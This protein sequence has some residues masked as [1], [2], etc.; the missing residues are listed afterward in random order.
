M[1]LAVAAANAQVTRV[2]AKQG[3]IQKMVAI[4]PL[5]R[6]VVLPDAE[7]IKLIK[8]ALKGKVSESKTYSLTLPIKLDTRNS[9]ID[10]KAN[11]HFD[12]AAE[13]SSA[14]NFTDFDKDGKV[15]PRIRVFYNAPTPGYYVFDFTIENKYS[16]SG[17]PILFQNLFVDSQSKPMEQGVQHQLFITDIKNAGWNLIMLES[18]TGIWKFYSLEI[19]QFK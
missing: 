15:D 10:G 4:R 13:V 11:M 14:D 12:W 1:F 8:T 5:S 9:Y 17:T 7:K 6:S 16:A 19:S 2:P 3:D 18:K